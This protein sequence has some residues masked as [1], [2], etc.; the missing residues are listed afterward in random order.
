MATLADQKHGYEVRVKIGGK[1]PKITLGRIPKKRAEIVRGHI[2][3][4]A[5][6]KLTGTDPTEKVAEWLASID[7]PLRV[8]LEELGLA[9]PL[10]VRDAAKPA[11]MTVRGLVEHYKAGPKFGRLKA[12]TQATMEQ[13]FRAMLGHLG[14]ET[15]IEDVTAGDAEAFEAAELAAYKPGTV[16]KRCEIATRLFRHGV[17]HGLLAANPFEN[18]DIRRSSIATTENAFIGQ[19]DALAVLAEL[20]CPEWKLLFSLARWAGVRVPSEPRLLRF[21]DVDWAKDRFRVRSPKTE[22]QGKAER[23][24]P[25]FPELRAPLLAACEAVED[26]NPLLLPTIEHLTGAAIRRPLEAAIEAAGLEVWPNLW[27]SLRST[28]ETELLEKYPAHAVC[29]WIGNSPAV[30]LKHYAQTP[31]HY[32][33]AA[34]AGSSLLSTA[35]IAAQRPPA[36]QCEETRP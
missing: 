6:A 17:K 14:A 11:R 27:K 2:E 29:G 12:G 30:A 33:E 23:W 34:A 22:G 21:A 32:F 16:C 19:A 36:D 20:P 25:I 31:R 18:G 15:P 3:A 10:A 4:L 13:A 24:V 28:R 5:V 26:G 7:G 35:P 9:D 1:R 8:R